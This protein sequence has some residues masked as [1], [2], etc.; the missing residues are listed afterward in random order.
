V[1]GKQP[2]TLPEKIRKNKKQLSVG[3]LLGDDK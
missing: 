1:F 2:K 3:E